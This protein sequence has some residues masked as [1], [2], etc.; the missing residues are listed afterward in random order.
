LKLKFDIMWFHNL[1][2][3]FNLYRYNPATCG[4]A[5][6]WA[7]LVE[8]L[9]RT[10]VGGVSQSGWGWRGTLTPPDPQLTGAWFQPLR[11]SSDILVSRFAFQM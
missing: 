6:D 2:S 10:A 11:L 4:T 7:A 1:L 3:K 9:K 8:T 5:S